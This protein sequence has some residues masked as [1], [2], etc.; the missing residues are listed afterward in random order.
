MM[1]QQ[2]HKNIIVNKNL[3][4][5]SED[6]N[7]CNDIYKL[8][9]WANA[10]DTDLAMIES[11][12]ME[13]HNNRISNGEFANPQWYAAVRTAQRLQT[14]LKNQVYLRMSIVKRRNI[15]MEY[16]IIEATKELVSP[17]MWEQIKSISKDRYYAHN[18]KNMYDE[19]F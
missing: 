8:K 15:P 14:I 7:K 10:I 3:G 18:Q 6:V 17:D 16:F 12:I 1:H 2:E 13:A 9:E 5:S 4:I 19:K 11:Q